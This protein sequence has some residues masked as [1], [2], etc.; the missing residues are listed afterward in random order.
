[1]VDIYVTLS[2]DEECSQEMKESIRP[3]TKK[4]KHL[5]YSAKRNPSKRGGNPTSREPE[6]EDFQK[7]TGLH[8]FL[9]KER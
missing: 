8:P 3:E 4:Y 2:E 7:L 6:T 1:M 9:R 5:K